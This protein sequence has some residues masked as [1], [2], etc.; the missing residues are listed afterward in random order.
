MEHEEFIQSVV[1]AMTTLNATI[2]GPPR[3]YTSCHS[4]L[5]LFTQA[6]QALSRQLGELKRRFGCKSEINYI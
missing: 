4:F 3:V 5:T 2:V 1:G 6:Y